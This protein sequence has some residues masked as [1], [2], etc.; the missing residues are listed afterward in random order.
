MRRKIQ[1][2]LTNQ[3][4]Q[5]L[6]N[7]VSQQPVE[8]PCIHATGLASGGLQ[9]ASLCL[10]HCLM[11]ARFFFFARSKVKTLHERIPLAGFSKLPSIPQIA[12]VKFWA[13]LGISAA[14]S[15][16]LRLAPCA[17]LGSVG[18]RWVVLGS[19]AWALGSKGA[20]WVVVSAGPAVVSC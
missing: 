16:P 11:S 7:I 3:A 1:L 9:P 17:M 10:R 15:K 14:K 12:K 19:S 4:Q 13:G 8:Q 18:R 2:L 5:I 20:C 6:Q